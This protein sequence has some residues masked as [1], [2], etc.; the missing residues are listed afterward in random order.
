[1]K[2]ETKILK[3]LVGMPSKDSW[4]GPIA[5]E[6]PFVEALREFGAEVVE[7]VYVYGDKEKPTPFFKRLRRVLKTAFQFR[8]ILKTQKFD[9]IHLNTAFDLKTILRDSVSLFLMKPN[10]AR[11][12]FKL[13]GSAAE[14]FANANFLTRIL[15]NYLKNRVDGFGVHTSEEKANF[16]R[17]G[18]E[19]QKFYFV[20][21]TVTIRAD[22]PENFV[23]RQKEKDETFEILFVSR[24]IAAKGLLETIRAC[25]ILHER[26]FKFVLHCIGDG[27]T[28][29]EAKKEVERLNLQSQVNFTGYISEAEV[30]KYFFE[31]DLFV[32]PTRHIEGFPN[33]LFKA[34]SVGLPI[35]TTKIRAAADYLSE[36]EN[37]L[38]CSQKP[39]DIAEKI[40]KLIENKSLRKKMSASNLE[41]G[42]TLLPPEIALEFLKI[43]KK[44]CG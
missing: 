20:K 11:V 13:H 23:R 21:N 30:A 10:G 26:G 8:K 12:F 25:S 36:P 18:F 31:S 39:E 44:L 29:A 17:L 22:L 28:G 2:P 35:V 34:V 6:P 16:R 1:M 27:E 42:K 9:L 14:E 7:E 4:G 41:F 24:F 19:E 3:L 38:F 37:C 43:Y 32:F 33:V 40:V 15:I 5:S